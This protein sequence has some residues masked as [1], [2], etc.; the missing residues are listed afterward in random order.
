MTTLRCRPTWSALV[1]LGGIIAWLL[2]PPPSGALEFPGPPPGAA[3]ARI[4]DGLLI[5][6]NSALHATW[7]LTPRRTGLVEFASRLDGRELRPKPAELFLIRLADGNSVRSSQLR[8]SG[9]PQIHR[10]EARAGATRAAERA[11]GWKASLV[12]T[13]ADGKFEAVWEATLRDGSHYVRLEVVLRKQTGVPVEIV[14]LIF[15]GIGASPMGEVDGSP[16]VTGNIF[17]ACEHPMAKNRSEGKDAV[18]SL[19]LFGPP[20]PG[21]P[22]RVSAVVGVVP[23]G[24]MR[25][26]FLCYLERERARPYHPFV[27]YISWFDIAA[28]DLKMNQQ[29]ALEVIHAFGRELNSKRGARLDGFVFDDGWDDNNSLWR[30]HSGFPRGFAPLSEAAAQYGAVLGTWISPWGGYGEHKIERLKFGRQQGFETNRAG[31]S[32]AGPEYY[33]RFREVCTEMIER[34]GVGYFKFDGIGSGAFANGPGA[35]YE[36]DLGA[37]LRLIDD[38]RAVRPDL[39]INATVGT[40]P[41]PFWLFYSDTVWRGGAD[42]AYGGIGTKRQQWM[43]YRDS[44]GYAIRTRRGPLYPFNSLKFQ[45]VMYARL[46]LAAEL[47]RDRKDLLDDIHMAAASGT[48]L[49]EF[50]VTPSMLEPWAWDAIA[51]AAGWVQRNAGVLTDS[52]GIGGDPAKGEVYGFASWSTRLGIVALRNP[53]EQAAEFRFDPGPVFELPA[54]APERYVLQARWGQAPGPSKRVTETGRPQTL[55][56]APFEVLVL[57][58][59]PQ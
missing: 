58:A 14:P 39:F 20:K 30:F 11:A 18:C 59:L 28:P 33:G 15:S 57:E 55:R 52:H 4:A 41:S 3:Q 12:L 5:L 53:G 40:W 43:T 13:S 49:Q 42:V 8:P 21:R 54:A 35:G 36:A 16:L 23:P 31:F 44:L 37:L 32:L 2:T 27:N 19:G 29:Q 6:E 56:L 47:N 46:S 10:V 50:F 38:L 1:P 26:G 48:Q 17:L 9:V 51:E 24:Q 45:S 22:A 7:S 25:R 34:Y